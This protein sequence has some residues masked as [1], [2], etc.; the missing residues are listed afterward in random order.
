MKY[1]MEFMRDVA[2]FKHVQFLL[3]TFAISQVSLVQRKKKN[4]YA[5]SQKFCFI[6]VCYLEIDEK[7]ETTSLVVKASIL[8]YICQI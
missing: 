1:S 2:F 4:N 8:V 3:K 7:I 5:N 6:P